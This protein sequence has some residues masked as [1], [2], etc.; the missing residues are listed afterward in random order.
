MPLIGGN[1][2][3]ERFVELASQAK[4]ID[5]AVAWARPCEAIE[6]LAA[7]GADI[8]IVVGISNNFTI[9]TTLRRLTTFAELRIVPDK[10][11]RIFHPKYY[12]FHGQKTICWVGSANLTG[13]GFGGN[14]ELVH[15]FNVNIEEDRD[16]FECL[17][18]ALEP[19]AMP[20]IAEYERNYKPPKRIP[21]PPYRGAE[22]ELPSLADIETWSDFVK[23]LRAYDAY[24]RYHEYDEN[25]LGETHSWLHT[26]S[27]GRE[28]VRL[29]DWTQLT[30]RECYILRG[31]DKEE[32]NW[33]LLGNVLMGAEYV[34]NNDNMPEVGPIRMQ[35][36]EQADQVLVADSG[37]IAD[38]ACDAMGAIRNLRHVEDADRRIGHAAATRWLA[39]ARPDYL[40]S[41]NNASALGLGEA[42]G[43]PRV[44]SNLADGYLDLLNWLHERPWFNK[45]NGRQP[46]DLL[47]R[48]IWNCRAALVD[49]FVYDV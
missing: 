38:V 42:S 21:P 23:G 1:L 6:A 11:P 44:S 22:P 49:V 9:P 20:T 18:E 27:A 47:E 15:E 41:V 19:D 32:G 26:I 40:V 2:I 12:C 7:S 37:E 17:W 28:V 46:D 35:I 4:R 30:R 43:L 48:D 14:V 3:P 31:R 10:P 25:V 5:V 39:L 16:W 24:Y 29:D 8:R 13:G 33:A 36:R 45:F 34:F